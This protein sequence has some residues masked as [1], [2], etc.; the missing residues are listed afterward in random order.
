MRR[1]RGATIRFGRTQPSFASIFFSA[2]S[3]DLRSDDVL[4]SGKATLLRA[5]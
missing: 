1:Q 3:D 5:P 2:R 4:I